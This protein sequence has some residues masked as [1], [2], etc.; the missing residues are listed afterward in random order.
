MWL[1]TKA[2]ITL[3]SLARWSASPRR[4]GAHHP[5]SLPQPD[6]RRFI[7]D[8][9]LYLLARASH[10]A[11]G[12]FH[13]VLKS[14]KIPV[15]HWRVMAALSSVDAMT[16]STLARIVLFKQPTLTKV[17]DRMARLGLVRRSASAADR[18]QVLVHITGEGRRLVRGLLKRAKKHEAEVLADYNAGEAAQLKAALRALIGQLG[19]AE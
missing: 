12:Q 17:I 11:S 8:Y 13:A 3:S 2:G 5:E 9:L 19:D 6:G 10:L 14:R 16:I 18:R 7:D 1:A 4:T 15:P